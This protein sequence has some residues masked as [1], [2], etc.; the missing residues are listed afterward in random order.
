MGLY[1]AV[2][3]LAATRARWRGDAP[4]EP[5]TKPADEPSGRP[6]RQC[7]ASAASNFV[8]LSGDDDDVSGD[9]DSD[10]DGDGGGFASRA[11]TS[12]EYRR[13]FSAVFD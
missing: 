13:R 4:D 10:A 8:G 3:T 5:A 11:P 2:G 1:R 7:R 12:P 9:G 6:V